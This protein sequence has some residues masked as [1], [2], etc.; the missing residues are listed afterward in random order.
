MGDPGLRSPII[1][2]YYT[3]DSDGVS[4]DLKE[5]QPLGAY[6]RPFVACKQSESLSEIAT[7]SDYVE[8]L[9][10]DA[11]LSGGDAVGLYSFSA[12]VGYKSLATKAM[13][14]KT[15]TFILKTYCLRFEAGLA[16]NEDF[17]WYACKRARVHKKKK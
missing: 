4:N 9:S 2:F 16:Q 14:K 8:E 13:K 7:I 1:R 11:A 15:R 17:N 10:T 12:S 3:Q 6:S 5:L